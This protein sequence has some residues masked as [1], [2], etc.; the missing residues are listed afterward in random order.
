MSFQSKF[1]KFMA[2]PRGREVTFAASVS[3]AVLGFSINFLPHGFLQY[4]YREFI[5]NYH[6]GMERPVTDKLKEKVELVIDLL[7][8]PDF[9]RKF[10]DSFMVSG[11]DIRHLGS[12]RLRFGANVG[13]PINYTYTSDSDI[14]KGAVIVRGQP[15][16]WSSKGGELLKEALV[17]KDDEQ[18]FAIAREVIY[19]KEK[20]LILDSCFP[21]ASIF[22]YYLMTH[23]INSKLHMFHRPLS[24]RIGLYGICGFMTYGLYALATDFL[25]VMLITLQ[26]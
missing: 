5:A 3:A 15:V 14:D 21:T 7:N 17:L 13:L 20:N 6:Q 22:M 23:N 11:F 26:V 1:L 8:L 4:K 12:L 19:M 24:F 25:E 10:V 18:V 16:D 9:E 2:S